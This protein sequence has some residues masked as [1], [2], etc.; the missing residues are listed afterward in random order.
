M[1]TSKNWEDHIF[2]RIHTKVLESSINKQHPNRCY[3]IIEEIIKVR[4][5]VE[6]EKGGNRDQD[7][8]AFSQINQKR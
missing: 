4:D 8:Q 7:S 2:I 5:E 1:P 3:I 6:L